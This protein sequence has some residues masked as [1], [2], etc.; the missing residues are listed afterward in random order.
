MIIL[1]EAIAQ[2]WKKQPTNHPATIRQ[3]VSNGE[4]YCSRFGNHLQ[5]YT[6]YKLRVEAVVL[7]RYRQALTSVESWSDSVRASLTLFGI[8]A[9]PH[10]S[11]PNGM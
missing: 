5:T 2:R 8:D 10:P 9:V 4:H 11:A 1:D 3:K 6:F 7:F